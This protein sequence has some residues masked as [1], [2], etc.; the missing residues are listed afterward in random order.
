MMT[1]APTI[2]SLISNLITPT[3]KRSTEDRSQSLAIVIIS[4]IANH[5]SHKTTGIQ[6]IL[7]LG[8]MARTCNNQVQTV[9]NHA[10]MAVSKIIKDYAAQMR[11]TPIPSEGQIWAYDNLNIMVRVQQIRKGHHGE[12]KIWTT[13][14]SVPLRYNPPAELSSEP[15]GRRRDLC[16]A[17][18]LPSRED[19]DSLKGRLAIHVKKLLC[20]H[21]TRFK[22]LSRPQPSRAVTKSTYR[23]LELMD[24]DEAKTSD[25]IKILREFATEAG[26][27]PDHCPDQV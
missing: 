17:D 11:S 14:L 6:T 4:T 24:K 5:H 1:N 15:A 21:F 13:R 18:L 20:T 25:N 12:M 19:M 3:Y 7:S 16:A 26:M 10:D 27:T 22:D 9:L 2:Y 8:S 23:P